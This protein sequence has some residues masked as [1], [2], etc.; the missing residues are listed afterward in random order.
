MLKLLEL[1]A[2]SRSIGK[3]AARRGW[4]VFSVDVKPFKGIDLAIDINDLDPRDVPFVPDCIWASPPC[5]T[6][7]VLTIAR[8]WTKDH[9]LKTPAAAMGVRMVLSTLRLIRYYRVLNPRLVWY[10]ENPRAKLRKLPP[11]R[12]LQLATVF[13]CKYGDTRMKPTDIWTNNLR[14][15]TNVRGWK[16]RAPCFPRN[17]NC[18]HE[19]CPRHGTCLGTVG[20]RNA[21]E[22][23]KI[24]SALSREILDDAERRLNRKT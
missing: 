13:Y 17:P 11:M 9:Q 22:R 5:T 3:V 15:A 19:R 4:R 12:E 21:Y 20:L 14:S 7:S 23:S 6:F 2:G 24:P 16:P 10:I 18:H 1:F 8:H